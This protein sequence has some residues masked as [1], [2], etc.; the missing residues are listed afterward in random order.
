MTVTTEKW[1]AEMHWSLL[2]NFLSFFNDLN[3]NETHW[4]SGHCYLNH[5]YPPFIN[6]HANPIRPEPL[7]CCLLWFVD[8]TLVFV[9]R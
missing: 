9:C 2:F 6:E 8:E 1:S 7:T 4:I 5:F 3:D